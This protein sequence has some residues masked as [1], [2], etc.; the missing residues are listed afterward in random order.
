M[1]FGDPYQDKSAQGSLTD[2]ARIDGTLQ[3]NSNKQDRPR[4]LE[5]SSKRSEIWGITQKEVF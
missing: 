3:K 5:L 2:I 4:T 1:N